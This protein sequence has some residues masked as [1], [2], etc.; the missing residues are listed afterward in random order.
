MTDLQA[1]LIEVSSR[2]RHLCPR[3]V[4]GV[5][6]GLAGATA[7]S[8]PVP[9]SDKRLLVFVETDGCFADGVEVAAGVSVGRRTL[10]VVD[11][12]KAAATF[13]D[14]ATEAAVRIVPRPDVRERAWR[15]APEAVRRYKAQLLG[16]Q[17]MPEEEL[18]VIRPV[19]LTTS[20]A[21]WI[22][23]AGLR[24]SCSVCGEEII[25]QREIRRG[26]TLLCRACASSAYYDGW[27]VD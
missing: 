27:R 3:Q 13:V 21:E 20:V 5:R 8:L 26:E 16:Y 23:R 14:V 15:Y 18:L 9:R 1:L 19:T 11:Y 25:N 12:G 2:H 6:I 17:R 10:K 24:V 7:L 22:S 4:L